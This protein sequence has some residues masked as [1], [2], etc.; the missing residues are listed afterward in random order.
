MIFRDVPDNLLIIR[1]TMIIINYLIKLCLTTAFLAATLTVAEETSNDVTRVE[2]AI[3][4]AIA[5][6]KAKNGNDQKAEYFQLRDSLS[7]G[8]GALMSHPGFVA[9]DTVHASD[10]G[11]VDFVYEAFIGDIT[12]LQVRIHEEG[13][14]SPALAVMKHRLFS[15]VSAYPFAQSSSRDEHV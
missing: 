4:S 13:G 8:V 15:L 9:I 7:L 14:D 11:I 1:I 12:A 3:D 2:S 6:C 10:S 5:S